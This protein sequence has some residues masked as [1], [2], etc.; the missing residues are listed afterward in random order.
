MI[1]SGTNWKFTYYPVTK[2]EVDYSI[3]AYNKDNKK[4]KIKRGQL[5]VQSELV[6]VI[7]IDVSPK[8]GILNQTFTFE[9]E[10]DKSAKEVRLLIGDESY[11]MTGRNEKWFLKKNIQSIGNISFSIIAFN[12]NDVKSKAMKKYFFVEEITSKN[13]F[14]VK[15]NIVIDRKTNIMWLKKP[16]YYPL[17]YKKAVVECNN[18]KEGGFGGWRLPTLEEFKSLI[19]RKQRMPALPKGHPFN[20]PPFFKGRQV[21][22]WTKTTYED[23]TTYVYKIDLARGKEHYI[24]KS[25]SAV[26]WPVRYAN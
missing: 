26:L 3:L 6:K 1:G 21:G 12:E 19:D 15:N 25:K 13:R 18:E 11:K 24:Q 16:Y 7:R 9:A 2:G 8:T 5:L 22:Y 4:G 20:I 17:T 10:T 14:I 23:M